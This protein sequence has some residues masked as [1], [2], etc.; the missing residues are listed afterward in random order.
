MCEMASKDMKS[1]YQANFVNYKGMTKNK[2][3]YTE[4]IAE[5]LL[6]H[7]DLFDRIETIER[8]QGYKVSHQGG[9]GEKTNRV[10]E[11]IAKQMFDSRKVYEG[12]GVLIDYQTPLKSHRDDRNK[13]IGKIDLLSRNDETRTIYIIELK[14]QDAKDTMLRCVLE[15]YT[16]RRIVS[17]RKLFESFN[18]EQSYSLKSSPLV[19]LNSNQHSEYNDET[20]EYLHSLIQ[21]LDSHPFFLEESTDFQIIQ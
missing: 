10:E 14:Q 15:G 2:E 13:G 3:P 20:R 9:N 11:Y 6:D 7:L 4:I 12:I 1:F 19:F 16:Y 18:I 5:W 8:E 21:K 17:Q